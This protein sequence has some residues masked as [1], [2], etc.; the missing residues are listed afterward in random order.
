LLEVLVRASDATVLIGWHCRVTKVIGGRQREDYVG[1]DVTGA[2]EPAAGGGGAS[3]IS[4]SAG[5]RRRRRDGE[6]V[7]Q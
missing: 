4:R 7:P 2:A 3:P 6:R 1:V 5:G